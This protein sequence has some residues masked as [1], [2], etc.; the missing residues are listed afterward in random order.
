MVTLALLLVAGAP[1]AGA[2]GALSETYTATAPEP[3]PLTSSTEGC[4]RRGVEDVTQD[5]HRFQL[6]RAGTLTTVLDNFTVDWDLSIRDVAT[7]TTLG[8]SNAEF[9]TRVERVVV[10]LIANQAVDI[11]ACNLFGGPT[12]RV[13]F[14]FV[15]DS[16]PL[17]SV[18]SLAVPEGDGGT[19]AAVFTVS[20]SE[21]SSSDVT[22]SFGTADGTATSGEDYSAKAGTL[23]FAP[24]TTSLPVKVPVLADKVDEGDETFS[25][26]LSDANGA[27]IGL[28]NGIGAI[29]DDDPA[30]GRR[31]AVGDVAVAE[32]DSGARAAIFTINLSK[33]STSTVKVS[34]AT[35]DGTAN[36]G[37]DYSA[38]AGT[39]SFAP[40]A[41]SLTVKVPVVGDTAVEGD[42]TFTLTLSAPTG[43]TV[44]DGAGV[45]TVLD[46]I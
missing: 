34:Y 38:K 36:S 44:S 33:P 45:G 15:P 8:F 13:A 20:L 23:I 28:G 7:D 27:T 12:A 41:T 10:S 31:L 37:Q 2:H 4:S 39:L 21:P 1:P 24:G 14:T 40:G 29:V 22:V 3:L 26:V 42:E 32:G 6:P 25:L 11:I 5:T 16:G 46:D 19:G 17:V 9:P 43:A 18:G 35:A 30:T